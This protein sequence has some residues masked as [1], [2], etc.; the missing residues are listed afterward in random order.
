MKKPVC[1]VFICIFSVIAQ[2]EKANQPLTL[3][4]CV[5]SALINGSQAYR[6]EAERVQNR[7]PLFNTAGQMLPFVNLSADLTRNSSQVQPVIDIPDDLA[8]EGTGD[9][10]LIDRNVSTGNFQT[11]VTVVQPLVNVPSFIQF[12]AFSDIK[13]IA[14]S[15]YDRDMADLVFNV[16]QYYYILIVM[17]RNAAV[18]ASAVAQMD[19][20]VRI[21]QESFRLGV[22]PKPE[23]LRIEVGAI[24]QRVEMI[25]AQENLENGRNILASMIGLP[26]PVSID[27]VLDFPDLS[28]EL[29]HF[30]SLLQSA[31]NANPSYL[32]AQASQRVSSNSHR[33]AKYNILPV[34]S[35]TFSYGYSSPDVFG[36]SPAFHGQDHAFWIV[37]AQLSWNIFD[38]LGWYSQRRETAALTRITEA[39]TRSARSALVQ[40]VE[41]AYSALRA[42]RE[43]LLWVPQ[44]LTLAEEELRLTQEQ[45]RLGV[46][47]SLNLLQS[48]VAYNQS[49]QQAISALVDYYIATAAFERIMGQWLE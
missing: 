7:T 30:D 20:Q 32:L 28:D 8:G 27:T 9:F 10:P 24:Q 31:L 17:Y 25:N 47:S 21:A 46:A 13:N 37:G 35:G 2:D 18:A 34:L 45:F 42:S 11:A 6:I 5:E 49:Q 4:Q 40:D 12:G 3:R 1:I 43:A 38:R 26:P 41:T 29:P 44:L 36:N 15:Q 23:L 33:A 16:K 14:Q 22:I 39:N 19:E 48:Q